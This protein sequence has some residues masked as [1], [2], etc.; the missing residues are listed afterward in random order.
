[1]RAEL[2][3]STTQKVGNMATR[4]W[5]LACGTNKAA[6]DIWM[7]IMQTGQKLDGNNISNHSLMNRKLRTIVP[8]PQNPKGWDTATGHKYAEEIINNRDHRLPIYFYK[9]LSSPSDLWTQ[10]SWNHPT[11]LDG[12]SSSRSGIHSN[13]RYDKQGVCQARIHVHG[14]QS[15]RLVSWWCW[16]QPVWCASVARV[17]TCAHI[18]ILVAPAATISASRPW[19]A[20]WAGSSRPIR[21]R[22]EGRPP[23]LTWAAGYSRALCKW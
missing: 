1:M 8:D 18:P 14:Y 11:P 7:R 9:Q 21:C 23:V 2:G 15:A 16:R 22:I 19:L 3:C 17:G 5:N 10:R 20:V 13:N 4:T 6:Y 12:I